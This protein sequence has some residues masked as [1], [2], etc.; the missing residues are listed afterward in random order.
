MP[1]YGGFAI[2]HQMMERV[3]V[4]DKGEVADG[5]EGQSSDLHCI[6]PVF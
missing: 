3:V 4:L 6:D 5:G 2:L 1:P